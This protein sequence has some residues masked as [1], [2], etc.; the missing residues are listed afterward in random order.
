MLKLGLDGIETDDEDYDKDMV[1]FPYVV[2]IDYDSQKIVS[3]RRN[4]EEND[5]KKL[6]ND[7]FVSYRFLPGTGFYGFGLYHLNIY[8][9]YHFPNQIVI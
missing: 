2:T 4:W 8:F 9:Y 5:E 3:I 6:R 1:A 7:Y